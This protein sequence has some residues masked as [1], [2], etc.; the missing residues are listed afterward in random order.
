VFGG[1]NCESQEQKNRRVTAMIKF[2]FPGATENREVTADRLPAALLT[3]LRW[4]A[5]GK[6]TRTELLDLS[7]RIVSNKTAIKTLGEEIK[8]VWE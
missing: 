8:A 4:F 3:E 1:R 6:L 7:A 2:T 5:L